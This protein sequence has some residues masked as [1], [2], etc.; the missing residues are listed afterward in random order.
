M[1]TEGVKEGGRPTSRVTGPK[2]TTLTLH[3]QTLQSP[4]DVSIDVPEFDRSVPGAEVRAPAAQ[5][6]IEVRD[7]V[8]HVPVTR[9]MRRECLHALSNPLHGALRRPPLEEVH[10]VV[11]PRPDASTQTPA[12]MTAEEIEPFPTPGEV[13]SSRFIRVQLQPEPREDRPYAMLGLLTADFVAHMTT[14]SSA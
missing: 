2:L 4:C 11:L 6:G 8:A 3:L 9:V 10:P 13:D 7:D 5:H 14:K 1:E 12:E